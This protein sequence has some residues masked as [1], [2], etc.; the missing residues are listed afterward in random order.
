[1][2]AGCG[3]SGA[4]SPL[5]EEVVEVRDHL[6]LLALLNMLVHASPWDQEKRTTDMCM[7]L[8]DRFFGTLKTGYPVHLTMVVFLLQAHSSS[9]TIALVR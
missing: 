9:I 3:E 6:Y 8:K 5:P 4:C 1:M 2:G 7:L